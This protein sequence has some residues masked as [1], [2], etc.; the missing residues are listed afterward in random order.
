[1]NTSP[2]IR[3]VTGLP[4]TVSVI[5]SPVVRPVAAAKMVLTS[6]WPGLLYQCPLARLQPSHDE[7]PLYA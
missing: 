4:R 6:I 2:A 3:R 1:M 7:S 5:L